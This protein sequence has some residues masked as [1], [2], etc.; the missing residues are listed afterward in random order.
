MD[1][2]QSDIMKLINAGITMEQL[3]AVLD[4][5]STE[6]AVTEETKPA[7]T[8]EASA[9]VSQPTADFDAYMQKLDSVAA[10][11]SQLVDQIQIQNRRSSDNKVISAPTVDDVVARMF[12][13]EAK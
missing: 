1:L 5:A 3:K 9:P 7:S 12:G 6:E 10:S 11:V 8:A 2:L 4:P 13:E